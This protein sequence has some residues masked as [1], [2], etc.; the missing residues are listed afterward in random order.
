MATREWTR[1]SP[2]QVIAKLRD[3]DAMLS[4]GKGLTVTLQSLAISR[5]TYDR[6]RAQ[7]DDIIAKRLKELEEENRRLKKLET[8]NRLLMRLMADQV[9]QI[10]ILMDLNEGNC[11]SPSRKRAAGLIRGSE[12]SC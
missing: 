1:H 7:Y 10:H 11:V 6:W 3:A 4:A 9:H 5:P 8:E 12:T 2:E